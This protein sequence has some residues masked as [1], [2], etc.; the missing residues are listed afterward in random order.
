MGAKHLI[1]IDEQRPAAMFWA[2]IIEAHSA[3]D[4]VVLVPFA[5]D[6]TIA[7][8]ALKAARRVI[9]LVRTPAQQLRLW[10]R[11]VPIDE[12]GRR[13]A[14]SRLAETT[15]RDTPLDLH[16]QSLYQ[17]TCSVCGEQTSAIAF[18][19]DP[20]RQV[21]VEKELA[22]QAC[23][24]LGRTS[25][26]EEDVE[27]AAQFERRGLSFWFILE[28]LV[29]AQDT[30]GREI[31]RRHLDSYSPRNLMALADITRKIDADLADDP[32][33]QHILRVWL[34]H[35]LD[36]GRL[37]PDPIDETRVVERNV[38][39]LLTHAPAADG[40]G[41]PVRVTTELET[42]FRK[43]DPAPNVA[44]VAGPVR[45]LA[46]G[47]PEE[48]ITLM[49]GAPPVLDADAWTWEQ[50]WSRWVF[51]RGAA[52][53]GGLLPPI[54]GWTRHVRALGATMATLLRTL[55]PDG[56]AIFHF[57][58]GDPDRA[59]ALLMAMAP[60]ARIEDF[61]YQ[62]P[63]AEPAHLFDAIGGTYHIAFTPAQ[64]TEQPFLL[65]A[66][67]LAATIE[68][69]VVDAASGVVADRAEPLPYG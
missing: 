22:C 1:P 44:L 15:K 13:R 56:H 39:H 18:I 28:W 4:D 33:S 19:L 53:G 57:H 46:R 9:L 34:L 21:P 37:Q 16:I 64:P 32:A 7:S 61:V 51:G 10:A 36:A 25:A 29:D 52:G 59:H 47:L 23:G 26:D 11:L 58:D 17:T 68:E 38:W 54:G 8:A 12:V 2:D 49:V 27:R 31:A 41:I 69:S 40:I 20:T 14:L 6:T 42:F 3:P 30:S 48:C 50:L 66:H 43:L 67:D 63:V 65:N 60:C 24:F 62:P 55:H 45:R 35:A 5:M